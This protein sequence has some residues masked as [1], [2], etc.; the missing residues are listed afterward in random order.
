MPS[1]EVGPAVTEIICEYLEAITHELLY[2]RGVYD[3]NIFERE[4]LYGIA[5]HKSRHP[6]LNLYISDSILSI[7]ARSTALRLPGADCIDRVFITAYMSEVF[8]S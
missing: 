2:R 5:V 7:K 3:P 4:R 6:E 8:Q 1:R